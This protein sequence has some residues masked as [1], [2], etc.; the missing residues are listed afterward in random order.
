MKKNLILILICLFT[1]TLGGCK[2]DQQKP[3]S[4][5]SS[6]GGVME[7]LSHQSGSKQKGLSMTVHHRVKGSNI[8]MECIV[9]PDFHFQSEENK[10]KHG[11]GQVA[12]FLDGKRFDT[13]T[14]GA[15]ILKG[16]PEGMHEI[17]VLLLH[18]DESEYGIEE[19]FRV[20]I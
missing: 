5:V 14:S 9:T 1:V 10:K 11:E 12:V 13:F 3:E 19:I 16:I 17:K 4:E 8:Y 20:E 2:E 15:F 7:V 6:P 18:N